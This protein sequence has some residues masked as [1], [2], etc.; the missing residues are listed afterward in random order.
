VSHLV[1]LRPTKI[2]GERSAIDVVAGG[3]LITIA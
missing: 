3:A 2:S 1:A